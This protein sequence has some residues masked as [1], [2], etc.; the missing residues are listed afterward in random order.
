MKAGGVGDFN[1][2]P[3]HG[4]LEMIRQVAVGKES[5]RAGLFIDNFI[6]DYPTGP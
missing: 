2:R 5:G 3:A 6:A 1:P 4:P